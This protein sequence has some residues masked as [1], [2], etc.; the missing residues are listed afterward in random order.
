M[1]A[2]WE[3][4]DGSSIGFHLHLADHVQERK[5]QAE[6][7]LIPDIVHLMFNKYSA[8]PKCCV[9]L[10]T[11]K[12]CR[13]KSVFCFFVS[14]LY[15][16]KIIESN[17]NEIK[18]RYC[19]AAWGVYLCVVW[20]WVHCL[21]PD[22]VYVCRCVTD[23]S[24]VC[25]ISGCN[26][27]KSDNEVSSGFMFIVSL[28]LCLLPFIPN[29]FPR[30]THTAGQAGNRLPPVLS[31]HRCHRLSAVWVQHRSHQCSRAG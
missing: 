5:T 19:V 11:L 26:Y 27:W 15:L 30:S 9:F 14:T 23:L 1:G 20:A 18:S 31:G 24:G 8:S 6:K 2:D 3:Q 21:I 16:W 22:V 7:Q 25:F 4:G 13:F 29:L 28:C 10:L 12:F 17:L